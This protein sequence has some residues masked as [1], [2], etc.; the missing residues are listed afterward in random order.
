MLNEP[1]SIGREDVAAE[2]RIIRFDDHVFARI[3]RVLK[4]DVHVAIVLTFDACDSTD[5]LVDV[6]FL[7]ADAVIARGTAPGTYGVEGRYR[8]RDHS[9]EPN[10]ISLLIAKTLHLRTS[11]GTAHSEERECR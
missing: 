4:D 7:L 1:V 9:V 5:D 2:V 11:Q 10:A 6:K 3:C 8:R